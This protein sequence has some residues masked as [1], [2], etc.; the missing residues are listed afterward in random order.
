MTSLRLAHGSIRILGARFPFVVVALA[1]ATLIATIVGAMGWRMGVPAMLTGGVLVPALVWSGQVWR[2]VTWVFYEPNALGLVFFVLILLIFGRELYYAWGMRR[3]LTV[4]FGLAA[5][6][7]LATCLLGLIW[8]EVSRMSY[9]TPWPIAEAFTIAWGV[10]F[11][12]RQILVYFVLPIGGRNL[13]YLTI[14]TVVVFALLEGVSLFVPHFAAMLIMLV[15]LRE[16][17]LYRVWLDVRTAMRRRRPGH[18]R[19]VDRED[20]PSRWVH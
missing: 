19:P 18:L 1:A 8:D 4:Y 14:G 2:L 20:R 7:A 11:P 10:M 17:P 3:F 6:A 13:V 12:G 16:I 5:G 15:Y 9:V